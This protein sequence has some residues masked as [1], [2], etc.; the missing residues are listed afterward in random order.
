MVPENVHTQPHYAG[1][2]RQDPTSPEFPFVKKD[3]P[4]PLY[5]FPKKHKNNKIYI[6]P[7]HQ[8]RTRS[9]SHTLGSAVQ[10]HKSIKTLNSYFFVVP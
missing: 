3:K 1:N 2:F 6:L 7:S 10:Q 8:R 4:P 5:N 9:H